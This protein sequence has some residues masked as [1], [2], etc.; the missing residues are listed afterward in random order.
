MDLNVCKNL[1]GSAMAG[2]VGGFNTHAANVVCAIFIA[3]GQVSSLADGLSLPDIEP[4]LRHLLVA[5]IVAQF[6]VYMHLEVYCQLPRV[7]DVRGLCLSWLLIC[8]GSS[9]DGGQLQL[10]HSHRERRFVWR[11]SAHL[12][13]H[14]LPGAGDGGWR[15]RAPCSGRLPQGQSL[16]LHSPSSISVYCVEVG[17]VC[18]ALV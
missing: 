7:H 6:L 10:H 12:C 14:A 4:I 5:C 18:L 3:T 8:A 17:Q 15:H 1:V 2:S 16:P 9:S 11:G 13:H